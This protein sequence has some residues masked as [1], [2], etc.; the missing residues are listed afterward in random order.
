MPSRTM[1]SVSSLSDTGIGRPIV[2]QDSRS[3]ETP[4]T[5]PF[6]GVLGSSQWGISQERPQLWAAA[7][8][9]GRIISEALN[10]GT[11][12]GAAEAA[13]EEVSRSRPW[14]QQPAGTCPNSW[15][16]G[17][18]RDCPL[19]HPVLLV[20]A[21]R[22]RS[23]L[24]AVF[25]CICNDFRWRRRGAKE[26][27]GIRGEVTAGVHGSSREPGFVVRVGRS[28]GTRPR[29]GGTVDLAAAQSSASQLSLKIPVYPGSFFLFAGTGG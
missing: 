21:L 17:F 5:P 14:V 9:H 1:C 16:D 27:R 18:A 2:D 13:G 10:Q 3:V 8:R 26:T 20:L 15:R 11:L 28:R 25:S 19:R 24:T 22:D 6:P 12:P 4:F 29:K 23:G 7:L